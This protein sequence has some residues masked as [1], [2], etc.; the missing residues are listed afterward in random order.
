MPIGVDYRDLPKPLTDQGDG[1]TGAAGRGFANG[2][3]PNFLEE[4]GAVADTLGAT[5]GRENVWNSDR[6]LADIFAN[7]LDQNESITGFDIATHP[8]ATTGAQIAGG[9]ALPMGRV[10]SAADLA[11]FGA[12]Y[13]LAS[14]L[15]QK[16]TI[17]ERMT[18]GV[19]GAGEGL[20]VTVLG[21]KALRAVAERAGPALARWR[22]KAPEGVPESACGRC[23]RRWSRRCCCGSCGPC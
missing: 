8:W 20:A 7:N 17:P 23:G 3:L 19:V 6:R 18:S 12:G 13:G 4:T 1:A 16:G 11:K 22:G 15:G 9:L 21:G 5:S 2:V 10:T 14:G